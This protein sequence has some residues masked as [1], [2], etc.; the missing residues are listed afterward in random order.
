MRLAQLV[1]LALK[2]RRVKPDH[3]AQQVQLVL[4]AQQALM[5]VTVLPQLLLLERF[6]PELPVQVQR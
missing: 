2:G 1:Q 6:R 3:K 4:L 5:V